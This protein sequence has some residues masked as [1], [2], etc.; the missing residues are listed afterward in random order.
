[1]EIDNRQSKY[2]NCP[3]QAKI[4]S[5]DFEGNQNNNNNNSKC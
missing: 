4:P 5:I 2:K 3:F 1:M